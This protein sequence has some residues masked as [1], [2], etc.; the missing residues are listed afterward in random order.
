MCF[1]DGILAVIT[2]MFLLKIRSNKTMVFD[3]DTTAALRGVTMLGIAS[4]EEYV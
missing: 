2:A 4:K 1:L 3:R